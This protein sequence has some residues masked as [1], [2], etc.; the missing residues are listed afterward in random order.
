MIQIVKLGNCIHVYDDEARRFIKRN[1]TNLKKGLPH[2][3]EFQTK[4]AILENLSWTTC[5]ASG[6]SVKRCRNN[7]HFI[8]R[9]TR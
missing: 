6:C 2:G 9:H 3:G 8:G 1:A 7:E 4:K 5:Q